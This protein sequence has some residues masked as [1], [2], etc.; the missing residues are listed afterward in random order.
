MKYLLNGF[1]RLCRLASNFAPF[2]R[3][4][5]AS[6]CK[7]SL[8]NEP[9]GLTAPLRARVQKILM[10]FFF[11]IKKGGVVYSGEES[12]YNLACTHSRDT[13]RTTVHNSYFVKQTSI[14]HRLSKLF[15]LHGVKSTECI[16]L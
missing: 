6:N 16:D 14:F 1:Y 10:K 8:A 3:A 5:F 12:K 4:A 9:S 15:L 13:G 11:E 7:V 2:F